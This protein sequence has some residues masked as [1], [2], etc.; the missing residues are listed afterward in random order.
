MRHFGLIG[1]PLSHSFSKKYFSE[2]FQKEHITDCDYENF[3]LASI[4]LFPELLKKEKPEGLNVTIPYK[5]SVISYLDYLDPAAEKIAAVNCIHFKNGKSTGFNT[6]IIGFERSLK[7]LLRPQHHHALILGTGGA[8]KAIGYVL[9]KL[10]ISFHYVSRHKK[11]DRFTY[12]D[13]NEE[14]IQQHTL[15]I[16]TTPLGTS[17]DVNLCP[18]IPYQFL[19]KEHLLYDLIYNPPETLFLQRGKERGAA[20]KNGY[21]M[22]LIQA[23]ASWEIWNG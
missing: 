7:P 2:K 13:L 5:E 17:P 18:D 12:G 11:P 8:S 19:R 22:L 10:N 23:E 9:S 16:N 6:D 15:I 14:I 20:I 4:E 1:F 3:P 21:E